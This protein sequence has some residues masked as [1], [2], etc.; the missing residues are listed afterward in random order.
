VLEGELDIAVE[1]QPKIL[2]L[3]EEGS[4]AGMALEF[5]VVGVVMEHLGADCGEEGS[6]EGGRVFVGVG[7]GGGG[8][9][10]PGILDFVGAELGC[11]GGFQFLQE[12]KI[13]SL[14]SHICIIR[15]TSIIY[16]FIS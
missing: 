9:D 5:G 7:I 3:C 11:E 4:D 15:N 1:D 13:D 8:G 14:C 6:V 10:G 12:I 2:D 16:S